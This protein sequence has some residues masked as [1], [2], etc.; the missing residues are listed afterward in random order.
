M[1]DAAR[2]EFPADRRKPH[3]SRLPEDHPRYEEILAAHEDA[4]EQGLPMYLDPY[5]GFWVQTAL[6]I[7]QTRSCCDLGC[8]HCPFVQDEG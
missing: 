3:P 1:T 8:R 2:G 6:S 4:M 7:W 5:T